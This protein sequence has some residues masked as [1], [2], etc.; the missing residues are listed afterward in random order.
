MKTLGK[1]ALFFVFYGLSISLIENK[2]DTYVVEVAGDVFG[3]IGILIAFN[4]I[5]EIL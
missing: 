2:G 4:M 5:D 1:L 3:A